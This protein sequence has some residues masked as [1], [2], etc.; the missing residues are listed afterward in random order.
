[1]L[2]A[3]VVIQI[4]GVFGRVATP[5]PASTVYTYYILLLL[6]YKLF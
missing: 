5:C 4:L 6:N 1:M 2:T 3:D